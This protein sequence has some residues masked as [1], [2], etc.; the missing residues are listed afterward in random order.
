MKI[1]FEDKLHGTSTWEP[2]YD[3]F[4]I[5]EV[6]QAIKGLLITHGYHELVVNDEFLNI[7]KTVDSREPTKPWVETYT[8]DPEK[9]KTEKLKI[10]QDLISKPDNISRKW[11]NDFDGAHSKGGVGEE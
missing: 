2:S 10:V 5:H 3:G 4:E 8:T 11:P 1:T 7:A 6:L 9:L